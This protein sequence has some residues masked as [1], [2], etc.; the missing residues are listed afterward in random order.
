[1]DFFLN[2]LASLVL[3][4]FTKRS[5][6]ALLHTLLK[7]QVN[8]IPV[9]SVRRSPSYEA[10]T[11]RSPRVGY[12]STYDDL[13]CSTTQRILFQSK[14][15]ASWWCLQYFLSASVS[16]SE[17]GPSPSDKIFGVFFHFWTEWCRKLNSLLWFG[18][19]GIEWKTGVERVEVTRLHSCYMF[20]IC[21]YKLIQNLSS[22]KD[23][24]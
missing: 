13:F 23:C 17:I 1:M 9:G 4:N 24:V 18:A 22:C 3:N 11:S 20:D 10:V 2:F 8:D 7:L 12:Y 6:G 16:I 14:T 19:F 21:G 5:S 15:F